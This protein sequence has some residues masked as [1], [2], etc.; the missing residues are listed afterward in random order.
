[1]DQQVD[2]YDSAPEAYAR[3][4]RPLDELE[5]LAIEA[6]ERRA[7]L[8]AALVSANRAIVPP[9]VPLTQVIAWSTLVFLF[10]WVTGSLLFAGDAPGGLLETSLVCAVVGAITVGFPLFATM[11]R[12]EWRVGLWRAA[13]VGAIGGSDRWCT[14]DQS[15][16]GRRP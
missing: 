6:E 10:E 13:A 1:V 4:S 11:L 2:L 14:S 16:G 3:V 15:R 7:R 12:V 9:E 5:R 8:E